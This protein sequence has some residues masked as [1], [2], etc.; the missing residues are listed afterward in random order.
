[1]KTSFIEVKIEFPYDLR[2]K[3]SERLDESSPFHR[4]TAFINNR[5]TI[6]QVVNRDFGTSMRIEFSDS[7]KHLSNDG[8]QKVVFNHLTLRGEI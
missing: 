3:Y 8:M 4:W 6:C 1:M 7:V 5:A 2:S